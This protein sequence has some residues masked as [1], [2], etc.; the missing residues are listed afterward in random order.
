[1]GEVRIPDNVLNAL[2][3]N[4]KVIDANTAVLT[5][6]KSSEYKD[7]IK[8][9]NIVSGEDVQASLTSA[10]KQ[11]YANIGKEMMAPFL[12]SLKNLIALERKRNEM[13]IEDK[14]DT[15]EK[16]AKV[17]YEDEESSASFSKMI[18]PLLI[19]AGIAIYVFRDKIVKFFTDAWDWIKDF[20][21]PVADFFDFSSEDSFVGKLWKEI[22]DSVSSFWDSIKGHFSD[23]GSLAEKLWDKAKAGWDAFVAKMN[24]WW[25]VIKD[26]WNAL[27]TKL[28][29][30]YQSAKNA[31]S[32][33]VGT[34][35]GWFTS[36]FSSDDEE[37]EVEERVV[38][39]PAVT[40]TKIVEP[41]KVEAK[42]NIEILTDSL[43][44]SVAANIANELSQKMGDVA[45]DAS[46]LDGFKELLKEHTSVSN[47]E[48]KVDFETVRS[49]ILEEAAKSGTQSAFV[50]NLQNMGEE[51]AG[52][53]S[54]EI[55]EN[56]NNDKGMMEVH[57]TILESAN[58]I[59]ESFTTYDDQIR[60]N[61]TETWTSFIENFLSRLNIN[62]ST[63]APQDNSR[64]SYTITPLHK[65]SFDAMSNALIRLAQESVDII[66]KQNSV[67]DEIK[68]LLSQPSTK[69]TTVP[70]S[71]TIVNSGEQKGTNNI[72]RGAK[73]LSG[74][75]WS[76]ASHWA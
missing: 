62:V 42:Q 17:Q 14:A 70:V 24:E 28:D 2:V 26:A 50:T 61:F 21:K 59:K 4:T 58:T 60:K 25:I 71:Q 74:N 46:E 3:E 7:E 32:N 15:V 53:F 64:N 10:E 47:G 33:I 63:E 69:D 66:T 34:A 29:E 44:N 41:E 31:V 30:F 1:M 76:A 51:E 5:E 35:K 12:K 18:V 16:E 20:F 27:M 43:K 23:L 54:R 55:D 48:V 36:L 38:E 11:R 72:A 37:K 19:G 68:Q 6:I 9:D 22:S 56:L 52:K 75:L 49:K 65:E 39:K 40:E 57:R 13:I 8:E 67:L 73:K 45:I